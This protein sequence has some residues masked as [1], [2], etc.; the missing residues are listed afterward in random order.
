MSPIPVDRDLLS[1][2]GKRARLALR[3]RLLQAVR[4]FFADRDYLEVET[5][6][7]LASPAN[8]DHIDAEPAGSGFLRTSPELHMKRLVAAGYGR[9]FQ[10]GPCFRQGETGTVHRPE[11]TM[12]EWYRAD[13]DYLDML[14][15]TKSLLLQVVQSL[16]RR[17]EIVYQGTRIDLVPWERWTVRDA[18]ILHAGWDPVG[19]FDAD[20]FDIDLVDKVEPAMPREVPVLLTDYPIEAG[21]LARPRDGQPGVAE[22][23]ELYVGGLEVAN[24]YSEL[25]DADEQRQRLEACARRRAERGRPAYGLD[26]RFLRSLA[27]LPPTG[28]VALG[29]DRLAM[30]CSDAASIDEVIAFPESVPSE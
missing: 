13:A 4:S 1:L 29:L 8:E 7:R 3:G 18:F 16:T 20:R 9:I 6:V 26:E 12:L 10:L 19:A 27:R 24:A 25:A 17:T 22:R 21:A 11:F 2:R 15:E 14:A 23:W 28:G 30:L 5:P